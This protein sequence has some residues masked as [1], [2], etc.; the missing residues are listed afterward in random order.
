MNLKLLKESER[1]PRPA[2]PRGARGEQPS[3][4]AAASEEVGPAA[5]RPLTVPVIPVPHPAAAA[6]PGL[7]EQGTQS[8]GAFEID[9]RALFCEDL[10]LYRM[11]QYVALRGDVQSE[12][13]YPSWLTQKDRKHMTWILWDG[14]W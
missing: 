6:S 14:L 13:V 1:A 12:V 10:V 8:D 4:A 5:A 7:P 11:L 3:G 2:T 9:V